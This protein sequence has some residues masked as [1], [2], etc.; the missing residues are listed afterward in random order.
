MK[1]VNRNHY[2]LGVKERFKLYN[3]EDFVR[4]NQHEIFEN[5][6]KYWE[7]EYENYKSYLTRGRLKKVSGSYRRE[8]K[9]QLVRKILKMYLRM[10]VED[11][12]KGHKIK[13]TPYSV[14]LFITNRKTSSRKY[15]GKI[16]LL[17]YIP[18]MQ[19]PRSV[20]SKKLWRYYFISFSEKYRKIFERELRNG[21]QYKIENR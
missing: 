8:A 16:P 5:P 9:Y 12:I 15:K 7:G 10:I 20:T 17:E 21:K 13:L 2:R 11:M 14:F 4:S 3:E 6:N 18:Y 19:L 1:Y